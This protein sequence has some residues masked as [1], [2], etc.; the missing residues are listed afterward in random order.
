ME[1]VRSTTLSTVVAELAALEC[2]FAL[3]VGDAAQSF[4]EVFLEG[5]VCKP[6]SGFL[7]LDKHSTAVSVPSSRIP[8]STHGP[9]L[10]FDER[11]PAHDELA[12]IPNHEEAV[13][14]LAIEDGLRTY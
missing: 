2:G 11:Q 8:R 1:D 4:G 14:V 5:A 13:L 7:V 9:V 10:S 3:D 12:A 6:S